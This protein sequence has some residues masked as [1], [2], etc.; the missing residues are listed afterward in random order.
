MTRPYHPRP[1]IDRPSVRDL[2]AGLV[3]MLAGI[4]LAAGIVFVGLALKGILR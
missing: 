3:L 2:M 4:G 1:W